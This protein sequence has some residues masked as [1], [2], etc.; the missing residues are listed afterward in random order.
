MIS[1]H[2]PRLE[3]AR[4]AARDVIY[5]LGIRT[6]DEIVVEDIIFYKGIWIS[7]DHLT[8][9]DGYLLTTARNNLITLR[10][11]I[12]EPGKKRFVLAHELGHYEL[13]PHQN[14]LTFCLS[15]DFCYWNNRLRPEEQEANA[16][17]GELLMPEKMFAPLCRASEEPSIGTISHLSRTF[18]TTL[19]ST[20]YRYIDYSPFD[21]A[22]IVSQKGQISWCRR[23]R[24]FMDRDLQVKPGTKVSINS[25]A[26]DLFDG[27]PVNN[28][29]KEVTAD[30][31]IEGPPGDNNRTLWED[32]L[33]MKRYDT[34]LT[35]LWD[36]NGYEDEE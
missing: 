28:G 35:M 33:L 6:P 15:E 12:K 5:R 34:V 7:E 14:Q 23:S 36:K 2:K 10:S 16:F 4:L 32:S 29:M 11:S 3:R 25:Y 27:K 8:S 21:C 17:A 31:W 18:G 13:H 1:S 22:M 20:A 19:L 9:G 26:G 24:G 30:A